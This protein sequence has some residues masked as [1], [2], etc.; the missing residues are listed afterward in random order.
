MLVIKLA[1]RNLG[2]NLRRTLITVA[3][4]GLGMSCGLFFVS[5]AEGVYRKLIDEAVR[6]NAGYVVV[7]HPE[8]EQAP[9]I[10]R[11]VASV[12]EVRRAAGALAEVER[13]KPQILG[14]AVVSTGSGS[15]GVGLI[16]VDPEA[17]KQDSPVARKIIAGRY[18]KADDERGVVV[19]ARLAERLKLQPG[20]KLVATTND[21]HG[22]L[23]SEL[24]RVTGVFEIG[25]EEMDGFVVQ[26]PLAVGRRIYRLGADQATRVGFMLRSPGDQNR[27]V[28]ELRATL[29]VR[30]VAVLPWE[31]VIPDLASYITLDRGSNYIFHA[32]ILFIIAF[33]IL[34]TILM[35]VLERKRE[36]A[37]M[38]ALGASPR[39]L[40]L[41]VIA[42]TVFLGI[43]GC[44]VGLAVGGA[45]SYYVEQY[46][47]DMSA[48]YGKE[49]SVSGFAI[50]PL[51][52]AELTWGRT[53]QLTLIVFIGTILIGVYPAFKATRVAIADVLRAR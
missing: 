1:W 36:F 18:L 46:G 17:E 52:R 48:F 40:R 53:A 7:Q 21:A 24:L 28:E 25:V 27:V 15:A 35:S 9:A 23:V 14:Q 39:L 11:Y 19:G 50:D 38:L 34:N 13:V 45:V 8:Y 3:S 49:M 42:E 16:G 4:I 44:A 51:M 33:T 26:V 31:K 29:V 37:A 2:R 47:L 43:I 32:I 10:D 5:L 6:I 30:R 22:E 41:Q 12:A 20:K